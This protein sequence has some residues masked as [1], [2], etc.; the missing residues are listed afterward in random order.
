M[1]LKATT[2]P[3]MG[4]IHTTKQT[5]YMNLNKEFTI[6]DCL[7]KLEVQLGSSYSYPLGLTVPGGRGSFS[8]D[9]IR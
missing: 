7:C 8:K 4:C 6:Y 3:N 1:I 9:D 5:H 2:I